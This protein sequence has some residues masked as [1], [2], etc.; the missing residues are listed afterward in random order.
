MFP[1]HWPRAPLK[2]DRGSHAVAQRHSLGCYLPAPAMSTPSIF[3]PSTPAERE[4]VRAAD[5]G[6]GL[7]PLVVESEHMGY[8]D[9]SAHKAGGWEAQ[10]NRVWRWHERLVRSCADPTSSPEERV[11][12]LLA[13]CQ[14]CYALRD[15]L[16]NDAAVP[17]DELDVLMQ[18]NECLR[19]CR[20]IANGSKHLKVDR[21]SVDPNFSIGREYCGAERPEQ[22]F[23]IAGDNLLDT[24]DLARKCVNAWQNF[25]T[26]H[27]LRL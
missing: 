11:D 21:P 13:F 2:R 26:D 3:I 14:S 15:W 25:L 1:Y 6:Y 10:A 22:W 9:H 16:K 8:L 7:Q 27:G 17:K 5:G 18:D 24:V 12:F 19:I 23:I 20:D 4:R